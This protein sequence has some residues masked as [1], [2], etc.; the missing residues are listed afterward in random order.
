[1]ESEGTMLKYKYSW[2]IHSIALNL[3]MGTFSLRKDSP[4]LDPAS[5]LRDSIIQDPEQFTYT[6][7]GITEVK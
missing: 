6:F 2:D 1:M 3:Q 7:K 4:D 5:L